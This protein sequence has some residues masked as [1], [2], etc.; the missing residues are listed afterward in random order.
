MPARPMWRSPQRKNNP[1]SRG[2]QPVATT[3]K[4]RGDDKG[5]VPAG[6]KKKM[7]RIKPQPVGFPQGKHADAGTVER[8]GLKACFCG[9]CYEKNNGR[10]ELLYG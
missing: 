2:Y 8:L 1:W 4:I 6:K 9:G 5:G 7:D 10:E 3:F